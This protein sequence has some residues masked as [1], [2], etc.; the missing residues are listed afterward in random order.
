MPHS[1]RIIVIA[2]LLSALVG[3]AI[4]APSQ[5]IGRGKGGEAINLDAGARQSS[6]ATFMGYGG[7]AT[8]KAPQPMLLSP[9]SMVNKAERF[10]EEAQSARDQ[11]LALY[12]T[13]ASIAEVVDGQAA[14][15]EEQVERSFEQL[16]RSMENLEE[17]RV[18]LEQSRIYLVQSERQI[19]EAARCRA[20]LADHLNLTLAMYEEAINLSREMDET[21][22]DLQMLAEEVEI[23]RDQS[24]ENAALAEEHLNLT[25][26]AYNHT[27]ILAQDVERS[28]KRLETLSQSIKES[29]EA[30]AEEA[31]DM[32]GPEGESEALIGG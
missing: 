13:T 1:K 32:L 21:A 14:V 27:L 10:M 7:F 5:E 3:S 4:A 22:D 30:L 20:L 6:Q 23:C 28:A 12:N 19:E 2:L 11:T 31:G 26:N 25:I 24:A 15:V 29:G 8:P 9:G 17:S 16:E 18:Q